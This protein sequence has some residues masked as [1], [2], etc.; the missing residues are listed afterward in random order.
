MQIDRYRSARPHLLRALIAFAVGVVAFS[1]G[2]SE[3]QFTKN[4]ADGIPTDTE[5]A[6]AVVA[7]LVVLVAGVIAVRALA[8]AIRSSTDEHEA[9]RAGPLAFL[10]SVIGY[11]IV[12]LTV[13]GALGIPIGDL[14]L[15][16][17]LTGVILGIAAQQ[18]LG[19]FFAGIVLLLARPFSVGERVL[20]R[21]GPLGGEYEGLVTEMTMFYV[22]MLTDNGPVLLPNAGVLAAAVGP[23]AATPDKEDEAGD[24]EEKSDTVE[25][26]DPGPQ[27]GGTPGAP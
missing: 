6:I 10:V 8:T 5:K 26:N 12:L 13:L 9:R 22:N 1:F 23:G 14:L 21:S 16:G 11:L 4:R 15:G 2:Q 20:L 3:G 18:S 7:A 17:A 25:L 24:E 19:N 27:Q